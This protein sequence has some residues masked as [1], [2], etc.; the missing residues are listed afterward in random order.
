MIHL[1]LHL[2]QE[3]ELSGPIQTRWMYPF[4]RYKK[5]MRNKVRPE[6]CIVECYLV[7]ESLT[8]CSRYFRGIETRWNCEQRNVDVDIVETGQRLDVFFQ[9]VQPLGA[10][11]LVTLNANDFDRARWYVLTNCNETA[12]YLE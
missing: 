5:W 4:E 10:A 6:G 7:D 3:A 2:S 11:K 12:S 1:A 9:Q 8:F